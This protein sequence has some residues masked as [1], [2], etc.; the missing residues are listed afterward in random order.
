MSDASPEVDEHGRPEPPCDAGELDTLIGFLEFQRAT[1]EWKT[2]GLDGHG[3]DTRVA[4]SSMTLGGMLKHLSFV[5]D[6]W[7]WHWLAGNEPSAPWATVDWEADPDWD[8]HSAVDDT[9]DGLRSMWSEAVDRS[10]E[11]VTAALEDGDLGQRARQVAPSGWAPNLRW[12]LTHMIEEYSRHNGHA[13]LIREAI[14]GE[15]GE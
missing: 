7:F 9:P 6:Y 10:R 12:I 3:L 8:W 2:R 14:D 4:A 15:T 5:E 13:D 11:C 1:L